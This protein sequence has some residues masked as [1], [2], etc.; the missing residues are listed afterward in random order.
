MF[1]QKFWPI[2]KKDF[3]AMI[4]GFERGKVNIARINYAMIILIPKEKASLKKNRPISLINCSFKI[5]FKV[6]NNRLE[7]ICGRLLAPNQTAFVIDRYILESVVSTYAII[8]E[9]M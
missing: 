1:Y 2:I 6:L 5:F 3:I 9:A 7:D 8:H 4:K